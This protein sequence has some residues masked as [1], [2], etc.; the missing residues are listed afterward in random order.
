VLY[1]TGLNRPLPIFMVINRSLPGLRNV[2][3]EKSLFVELDY[4]PVFDRVG[5]D[6]RHSVFLDANQMV[7]D[8]NLTLNSIKLLGNTDIGPAEGGRHDKGA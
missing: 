4:T 8:F 5:D 6:K 1:P 2:A 7:E 3:H